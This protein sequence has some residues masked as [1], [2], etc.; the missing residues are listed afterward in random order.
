MGSWLSILCVLKVCVCDGNGL[1]P[2]EN[3]LQTN[4]KWCTLYYWAA[5]AAPLPPPHAV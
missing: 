2:H 3:L 4:R 1:L 5:A